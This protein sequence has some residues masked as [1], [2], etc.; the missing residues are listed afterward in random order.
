MVMKITLSKKQWQM[1]GHTTGWLKVQAQQNQSGKWQN[2]VGNPELR[3]MLEHPESAPKVIVLY[4]SPGTGKSAFAYA[5]ADRLGKSVYEINMG[6]FTG[7]WV[8]QANRMRSH[9]VGERERMIK[10]MLGNIP[11]DAVIL[12]DEVDRQMNFLSSSERG[13]A[14]EVTE[15]G[16]AHEV[17][18]NI[19]SSILNYLEKSGNYVV[20]TTNSIDGVDTALLERA[21]VIK[22][23]GPNRQTPK[24]I[25]SVDT[26]S[27]GNM[28]G[29]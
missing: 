29:K 5:L 6:Q 1:I 4:G 24:G 11:K 26:A 2:Y 10:E 22:T 15:Q 9:Y 20:M 8:G 25:D 18:Q 12:F 7:K 19:A 13:G 14:H 23:E 17:T 3:E 21:S 28:E 27:L 16:G